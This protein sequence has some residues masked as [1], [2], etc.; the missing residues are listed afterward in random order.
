MPEGVDSEGQ[1]ENLDLAECGDGSESPALTCRS[2]FSGMS[3]PVE[4]PWQHGEAFPAGREVPSLCTFPCVTCSLTNL[5]FGSRTSMLIVSRQIPRKVKT[6]DGLM[7]GH[8]DSQCLT[9]RL[10]GVGTIP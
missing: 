3:A 8:W 9:C 2:S 1:T 6:V 4:Q 5:S 7:G 10:K